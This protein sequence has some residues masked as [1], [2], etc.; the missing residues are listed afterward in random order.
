MVLSDISVF[1]DIPLMNTIA[2]SSATFIAITAGFFT[3]KIISLST[4]KS[5]LERRKNEIESELR[6]TSQKQ[7]EYKK[8]M[9]NLS[10]KDASERVDDFV[11]IVITSPPLSICAS[12]ISRPAKIFRRILWT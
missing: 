4:E 9:D 11:D 7:S 10:E 1:I 2:Q 5:R 3:T 12:H 8:Q 6:A